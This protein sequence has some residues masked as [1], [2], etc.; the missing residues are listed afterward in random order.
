MRARPHGSIYI[1]IYIYRER[2]IYLHTY[3]TYIHMCVFIQWPGSRSSAS[4]TTESNDKTESNNAANH[5]GDARRCGR[6]PNPPHAIL[7]WLY[8][9]IRYY[10]I[11]CYTMLYYTILYF[12]ILCYTILYYTI[13]ILCY[14]MLCYAMLYYAMLYYAML[15]P[16][17]SLFGTG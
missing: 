17:S 16:P 5:D 8:Y 3:I 15:A 4:P 10:T 13:T 14:T 6:R 1:Y 11:L 7:P 12:T 2:E 9:T